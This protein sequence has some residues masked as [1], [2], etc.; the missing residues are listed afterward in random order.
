MTAP[1]PVSHFNLPGASG[2]PA[3]H[4]YRVWAD[5]PRLAARQEPKCKSTKVTRSDSSREIGRVI[6]GIS[7]GMSSRTR[8][9][10][11]RRATRL[12][13]P[14]RAHGANRPIFGTAKGRLHC[15]LMA[16]YPHS[17]TGSQPIARV[18]L[19]SLLARWR[20]S[21][22]R[23]L[24]LWAERQS[25]PDVPAQREMADTFD[26]VGRARRATRNGEVT[27]LECGN[28]AGALR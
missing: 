17:S 2:A 22:W 23:P 19:V 10:A 21:R 14:I 5:C 16:S 18:A 25:T 28:S 12:Q 27:S 26:P 11:T 7:L 1:A 8:P 13:S 20:Q 4:S 6:R 9:A 3:I 24:V 15:F